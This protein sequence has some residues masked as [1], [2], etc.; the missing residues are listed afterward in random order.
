LFGEVRNQYGQQ[1]GL[2]GEVKQQQGNLTK[3]LL[4]EVRDEYTQEFNP[5]IEVRNTI[6][7]A[8]KPIFASIPGLLGT[9]EQLS[10]PYDA[11]KP[12][13][14]YIKKHGNLTRKTDRVRSGDDLQVGKASV[15]SFE[16][17][18]SALYPWTK[19]MVGWERV[20]E[21][22]GAY[23]GKGRKPA[24]MGNYNEIRPKYGSKTMKYHP[25]KRKF[26]PF[27]RTY[28]EK[29]TKFL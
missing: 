11:N 1:N 12:R 6:T 15:P 9:Q 24:S 21:G 3:S 26:T 25:P 2:F 10:R 5:T 28:G 23:S 4:G 27:V 29:F 14:M 19:P 17:R 22:K 7:E 8:P 20:Y 16:K 18:D 13:F